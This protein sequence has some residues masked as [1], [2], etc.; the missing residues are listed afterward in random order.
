M[1]PICWGLQAP[2][3]AVSDYQSVNCSMILGFLTIGIFTGILESMLSG[4]FY[5]I[6]YRNR[7][8][9]YRISLRSCLCSSRIDLGLCVK[10]SGI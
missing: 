2:R 5:L 3:A 10:M 6:L 1:G 8:I 9:M 4:V 7:G